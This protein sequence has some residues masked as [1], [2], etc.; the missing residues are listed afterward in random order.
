MVND[1]WLSEASASLRVVTSI[2]MELA[3][4]PLY[5][6]LRDYCSTQ[7]VSPALEIIR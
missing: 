4:R 7:R 6:M 3:V 1:S 5:S 2:V